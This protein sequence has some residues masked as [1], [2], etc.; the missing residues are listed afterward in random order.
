MLLLIGC[1]QPVVPSSQLTYT[2]IIEH[3]E[4]A[5]NAIG[6]IF[7]KD[8]NRKELVNYENINGR[9]DKPIKEDKESKRL[10]NLIVEADKKE[11]LIK[12]EKHIKPEQRELFDNK[13]LQL[14]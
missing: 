2:E 13:M 12:I 3:K 6:R 9:F 5:S 14:A 11:D 1:G 8:L 7:G 4:L 10:E